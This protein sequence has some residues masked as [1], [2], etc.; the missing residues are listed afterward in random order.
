M[1]Q[2]TAFGIQNFFVKS[3]LGESQ[4]RKKGEGW[5]KYSG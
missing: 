4:E 5:D 1:A 3:A 2:D